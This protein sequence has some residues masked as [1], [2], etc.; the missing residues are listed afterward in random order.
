M[1][2]LTI[3]QA[4]ATLAA[5]TIGAEVGIFTDRLLSAALVVVLVTVIVSGIVTRS[6][7]R[8]IE[9][10]PDSHPADPRPADPQPAPAT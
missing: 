2:G 4:A 10:D 5:V 1:F 8:R 6:A 3:A 7:A 9:S